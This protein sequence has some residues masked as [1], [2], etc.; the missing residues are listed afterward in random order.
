MS[1]EPI[2]LRGTFT[3]IANAI[4]ARYVKGQM[5]P[6][7]MPAKIAKAGY[8][9][10]VDIGLVIGDIDANGVLQPV[11][12]ENIEIHSNEALGIAQSALMNK[13][14][15]NAAITYVGFPMLQNV[16]ESA[17]RETFKSCTNI[18]DGVF[19]SLETIERYGMYGIFRSC[20]GLNN[21]DF[22][23]LASV[24]E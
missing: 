23:S 21:I 17:F 20:T 13:F 24:G 19:P 12:A 4:R 14:Q 5:K 8:K 15:S 6:I 1:D 7:E 2:T 22:E 16:G 9:L 10:G 11:S 3:D 18:T